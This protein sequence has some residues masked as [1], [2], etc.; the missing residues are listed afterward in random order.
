[1]HPHGRNTKTPKKTARITL[2]KESETLF[3]IS[4]LLSAA[5]RMCH[6]YA[7]KYTQNHNFIIQPP[8]APVNKKH[9]R[10]GRKKTAS[11]LIRKRSAKYTIQIMKKG[12][13]RTLAELM[14]EAHPDKTSIGRVC[15]GFSF[16]GYYIASAGIVGIAPQTR[17]RFVERLTRLYEQGAPVER[18]GNYVR[19]WQRWLVSGLGPYRDSVLALLRGSCHSIQ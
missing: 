3:I 6:L 5:G 11:Q 14:L 4:P 15:R 1:L 2:H 10:T 16:L 7:A 17:K 19:R 13:Q 8:G 18:I 9:H 12:Q